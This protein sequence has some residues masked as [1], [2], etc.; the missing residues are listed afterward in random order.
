M[1]KDELDLNKLKNS[2]DNDLETIFP[3]KVIAS[4]HIPCIYKEAIND[5]K[6][7]EQ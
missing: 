1:D 4:I 3:A 7:I 6:Y 2:L 5:L